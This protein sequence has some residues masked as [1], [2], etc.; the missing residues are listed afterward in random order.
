[1]FE[2]FRGVGYFVGDFLDF[3]EEYRCGGY[4]EEDLLL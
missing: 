3:L 1:M 2:C 4:F